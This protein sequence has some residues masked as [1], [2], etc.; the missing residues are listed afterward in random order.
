MASNLFCNQLLMK[1]FTINTY[2]AETGTPIDQSYS[3]VKNNN[4]ADNI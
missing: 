3:I 2:D 1:K 4:L